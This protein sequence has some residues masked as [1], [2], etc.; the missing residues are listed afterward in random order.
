MT[1]VNRT[2]NIQIKILDEPVLVR[3]ALTVAT[4]LNYRLATFSEVMDIKTLSDVRNSKYGDCTIVAVDPTDMPTE[5]GWYQVIRSADGVNFNPINPADAQ[6]LRIAGRC[7]EVVY[8]FEIAPKAAE[9][10]CAVAL[11]V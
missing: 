2:A 9:G 3:D 7:S 11:D 6:N 10:K 5:R 8:V 1:T 4:S